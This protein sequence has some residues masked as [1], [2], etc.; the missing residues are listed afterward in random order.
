MAVARAL[1]RG[2]SLLLADEPTGNLDR[3]IGA[4]VVEACLELARERGTASSWRR[5]TPSWRRVATGSFGSRRVNW[6][7]REP[8]WACTIILTGLRPMNG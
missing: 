5:T 2:P 3:E 7:R 8:F 1:V 6:P 4:Q